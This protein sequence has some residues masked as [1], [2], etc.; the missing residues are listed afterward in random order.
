[1]TQKRDWH[2]IEM[3]EAPQGHAL[4]SDDFVAFEREDGQWEL[5][6]LEAE[7]VVLGSF[8]EVRQTVGGQRAA[9]PGPDVRKLKSRLLR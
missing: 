5:R 1:M 2:R 6:G 8:G 3:S 9:N 4:A 7:P